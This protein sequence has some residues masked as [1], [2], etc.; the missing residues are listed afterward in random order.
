M[1]SFAK[2]SL[3][4][5]LHLRGHASDLASAASV[6]RSCAQLIATLIN[7]SDFPPAPLPCDNWFGGC[8]G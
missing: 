4:Q 3:P 6:E 2:Q 7:I 1:D 8:H 5:I